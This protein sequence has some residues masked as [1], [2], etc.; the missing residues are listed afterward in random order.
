M[1]QIIIFSRLMQSSMIFTWCW[2]PVE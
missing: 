1:R 2:T